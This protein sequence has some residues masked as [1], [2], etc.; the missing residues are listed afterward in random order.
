MA[1][2]ACAQPLLRFGKMK[3]Y[4]GHGYS[5]DSGDFFVRQS[6]GTQIQAMALSRRKRWRV[7]VGARGIGRWRLLSSC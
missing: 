1:S 6:I 7:L 3:A 2:I 5:K 4:G